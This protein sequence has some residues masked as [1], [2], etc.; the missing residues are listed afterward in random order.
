MSRIDRSYDLADAIK[1]SSSNNKNLIKDS[2]EKAIL[3]LRVAIGERKNVNPA[4]L[5]IWFVDS[6]SELDNDE[7]IVLQ[8][9]DEDVLKDKHNTKKVSA[10]SKDKRRLTVTFLKQLCE[11]ESSPLRRT[12]VIETR[13]IIKLRT[14]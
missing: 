1:S 8:S 10:E 14:Q 13:N 2:N 3:S 6:Y 7:L 4:C 9:A 12:C 5:P 11:D